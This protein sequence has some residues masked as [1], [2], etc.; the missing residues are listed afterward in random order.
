VNGD[1]K[2]D[3]WAIGNDAIMIAYSNGKEF[4]YLGSAVWSFQRK[5]EGYEFMTRNAGCFNCWD[6][7]KHPRLAGDFNGDGL[8]DIMGIGERKTYITLFNLWGR[9]TLDQP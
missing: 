6:G 2:A 9:S 4:E 8:T 7:W 5:L 1:G 3:L